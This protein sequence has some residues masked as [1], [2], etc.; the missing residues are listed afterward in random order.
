MSFIGN[1]PD[2]F[3]Y[4]ST[5]YDHF[6]GT[7][8]QTVYTLSRSVSANSDIFVTVNSVP[9][10]P[11]VAYYV[12]DLNTLTFTSAPS[13]LANNIVVVYR[14]FVQ[15]SLGI[16]VAAKSITSYQLATDISVDGS[17]SSSIMGTTNRITLNSIIPA[18]TNAIS[19]NSVQIAVGGSTFVPVGS[20]YKVVLL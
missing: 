12:T 20:T 3:G 13:A 2:S 15:S 6:S 18:N 11:G 1:R 8:S 14:N 9:Q 4:S 7:G 10:D 17:I 16:A 19:I 5:T